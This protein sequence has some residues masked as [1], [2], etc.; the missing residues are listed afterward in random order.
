MNNLKVGDCLQ[1]QCYKHNKKIHRSWD[2]AIVLDIQEDYIVL[3]DNK[4]LV[5]EADGSFWKT[6]EPAILYFFKDR[7][8]NI[9]VQLKKNRIYYYCNIAS[10]YII[11]DQTVKYIDYDLDLRVFPN[12]SYKILDR[13]EYQ[14]H[15][16]VMHYS[17]V[18]D[19]II[20]C[21][22]RELIQEY[23][24]HF[25]PFSKPKNL[26]YYDLYREQVRQIQEK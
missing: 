18:L 25:F 4:A 13:M 26:K 15:K 9:I 14:Y 23:R 17:K 20:N 6:K 19:Q 16:K 21:S 10:P 3:G 22:L 8:Y 24:N 12:G 11:E 2:K 1:I 5:I 7:W